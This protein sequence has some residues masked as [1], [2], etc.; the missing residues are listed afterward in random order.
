MQ[1]HLSWYVADEEQ[2]EVSHLQAVLFCGSIPIGQ[3]LLA[4]LIKCA[5][6]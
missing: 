5:D 4:V 6:C 1:T 2:C 3:K